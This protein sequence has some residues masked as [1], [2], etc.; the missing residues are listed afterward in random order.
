MLKLTASFSALLPGSLLLVFFSGG[1]LRADCLKQDS[2][3]SDFPESLVTTQLTSGVQSA[4]YDDATKRYT[5]GVLGDSIEPSTLVVADEHGCT[6]SVVLDQEHVFEDL[7]PRLADI[8]AIP[9]HEVVTVRSHRNY[10]AQL[11]IYQL[12]EDNIS[13]LTSTP[14]IGTSN[15]WLAP[16]GIADFN[17]DGDID[18]AYV[19]RPHLAKTLRVW[20][21]RDGKLEQIANKGGHS[22]HRIGEDFISGGIRTCDGITS[23]ITADAR[24]NRILE[25]TLQNNQLVSNDVGPFSGTDSFDQAMLCK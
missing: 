25:T 4:W 9:G 19:D 21:Y 2:A 24:W 23:M 22:N 1:P 17:N 15:R 13:L 10:G 6:R 12:A 5:H 16:V 18:I 20:S 11:A 7:T 3:S 14:Y 8:D